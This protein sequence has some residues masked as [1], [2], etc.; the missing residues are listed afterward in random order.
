MMFR[1]SDDYLVQKHGIQR[2]AGARIVG[3]RL[4]FF[5]M[6]EL[7]AETLTIE[8]GIELQGLRES[9]RALPPDL[10]EF[11]LS[12]ASQIQLGAISSKME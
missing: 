3:M 12:V 11:I 7:N 8:E 1:D 4:G 9:A 2:C 10:Q 5:L 6:R